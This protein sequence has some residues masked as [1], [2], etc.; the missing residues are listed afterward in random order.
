[1]LGSM[2]RAA[3]VAVVVTVLLVLLAG[4]VLAQDLDP[5]AVRAIFRE[6][7]D[8]LGEDSFPSTLGYAA[9]GVVTTAGGAMAAVIRHLWNRLGQQQAVVESMQKLHQDALEACRTECRKEIDEVRE[10]LRKEQT[11]RR[12][13]S[14]RLLREQK[15]IM[16]EV[17]VTCSAISQ[18]LDR[19][20]DALVKLESMI[21]HGE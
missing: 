12:E 3:S 4:S 8:K 11:E 7:V 18:S 2:S 10:Q 20:T 14:E 21:Q 6:E 16:R 9:L 17:M 15:E 13:E 19:N 1:M 5:D